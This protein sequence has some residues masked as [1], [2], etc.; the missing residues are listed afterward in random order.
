M[1]GKQDYITTKPISCVFDGSNILR[2]YHLST[3][4]LIVSFIYHKNNLILGK[5]VRLDKEIKAY[6]IV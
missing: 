2:A 5:Q 6:D 3:Q 1:C 4:K